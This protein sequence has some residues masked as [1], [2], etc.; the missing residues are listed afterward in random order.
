MDLGLAQLYMLKNLP[1]SLVSKS[2]ALYLIL[3]FNYIT[4]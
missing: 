2:L 3:V 1:I 4:H